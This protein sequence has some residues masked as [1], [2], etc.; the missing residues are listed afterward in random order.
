MAFLPSTEEKVLQNLQDIA[1]LPTEK[2]ALYPKLVRVIGVG[3]IRITKKG[4]GLKL[5]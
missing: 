5:G 2:S 4:K 1:K 3:Q